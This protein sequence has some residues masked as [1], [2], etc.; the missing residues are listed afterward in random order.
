MSGSV[1]FLLVNAYLGSES[2]FLTT[3]PLKEAINPFG[4]D[5]LASAALQ[6]LAASKLEH[7][8]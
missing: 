4:D 1:S 3:Y 2:L 5:A 6:D 8:N 7:T